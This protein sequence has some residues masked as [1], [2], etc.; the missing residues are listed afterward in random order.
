MRTETYIW[1]K[2]VPKYGGF[3]VRWGTKTNGMNAAMRRLR[4][5]IRG[6][7]L[8]RPSRAVWRR[9]KRPTS[10]QVM[11]T[12]YG[13]LTYEIIRRVLPPDGCAVDVG[14]H[15]GTVLEVIAEAAPFGEHYA[16]EP[17]PGLAETL[18]HKF[19]SVSV[20]QVA[21]SDHSGT[22]KFQQVVE[23]P[24]YSGLHRR[25]YPSEV[26][27]HEIQVEVARMDDI[28]PA[29]SRVDFIKIDVEGG[30]LDVL[31]GGERTITRF[32]PT[33]VFEWGDPA[34]S[35]Y[36]ASKTDVHRFLSQCGLAVSHLHDFVEGKAP[37]DEEEFLATAGF[38]FVAHPLD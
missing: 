38:M 4:K 17:L 34:A 6:T 35:P 18:R 2:D 26:T 5:I 11:S 30:E 3:P 7:P 12:V 25:L 36:G 1:F 28:L 13:E 24:A 33:V 21:L 31:R 15:V 22:E 27:V 19:P 29:G 20:H 9:L 16:F 37:M 14:C 23:R 32:R 10:P 8:E